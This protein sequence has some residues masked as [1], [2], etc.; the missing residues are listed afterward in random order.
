M[1]NSQE[2][3]YF[4]DQ[5]AGAFKDVF[6]VERLK[7]SRGWLLKR[8]IDGTRYRDTIALY[9]FLCC[10]DWAGLADDLAA[11]AAESVCVVAATD[12][13][14]DY[15]R[16]LLQGCFDFVRPFKEHFVVDTSMRLGG[17]IKPSHRAAV[18]RARKHVEVDVVARPQDHASDW[19]CLYGVLCARHNITGIRRFSEAALTAQLGVPGL[20]MFRA[21]S[22]ARTVGLDL[23]YVQGGC[24]QGHL[25][26]FDDEGYG[27]R[28]SYATKMAVLE[29]FHTRVTLINL[30]GGITCDDGLSAFKRGFST[31]T[32]LSLLCGRVFDRAA[33]DSLTRGRGI[34]DLDTYF[35][36]YRTGEKS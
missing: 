6:E 10:H 26:A 15:T 21:S 2:N 23:W 14:G 20:V 30:G 32:R 33:Y 36:A 3:G 13:T 8:D 24:A 11:I 25:A 5:Y 17:H 29:Y 1:T 4:S 28:A 35:P 9:P 31:G 22:G 7:R 27:L 19:I 18:T 12:P 16:E 34:T